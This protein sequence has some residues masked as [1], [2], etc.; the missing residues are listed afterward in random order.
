MRLPIALLALCSCALAQAG[1]AEL[2]GAI[3]D[4][5]GR[6]VPRARVVCS[7]AA[8]GARSAT[9]SNERGEYHLLGLAAGDYILTIEA[10]GFR[11]Y[12]AEGITLRLGDQVRM[13]AAL[14]LGQAEQSVE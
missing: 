14:R 12:R 2:F 10:A 8:T 3:L 13:D 9:L 11:P 7:A 1:K 4:P 5:S 6:S